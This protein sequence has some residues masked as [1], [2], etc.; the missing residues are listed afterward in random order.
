MV[1][2]DGWVNKMRCW[3]HISLFK[4]KVKHSHTLHNKVK[5]MCKNVTDKSFLL[6]S[7][8]TVLEGIDK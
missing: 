1:R 6:D 2:S 7:F 3:T 4:T 8:I 5:K